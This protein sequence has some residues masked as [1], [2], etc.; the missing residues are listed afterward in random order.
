M[1]TG[2][3]LLIIGDGEVAL[4]ASDCLAQGSPHTGRVRN[5]FEFRFDQEREGCDAQETVFSRSYL[6]LLAAD[7]R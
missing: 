1:K 4:I 3:R 7:D 5:P 6:N 2:S